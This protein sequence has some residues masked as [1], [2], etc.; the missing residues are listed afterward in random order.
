MSFKTKITLIL[1]VSILVSA[2]FPIVSLVLLYKFEADMRGHIQ[3]NVNNFTAINGLQT[4]IVRYDSHINRY[5]GTLN[6]NWIK[7]ANSVRASINRYFDA[8]QSSNTENSELLVVLGELRQEQDAYFRKVDQ[9]V[10]SPNQSQTKIS[11]LTRAYNNR[12]VAIFNKVNLLVEKNGEE[13]RE[14]SD[15]LKAQQAELEMMAIIMGSVFIPVLIISTA[16]IYRSTVTPINGI[17]EK[18]KGV[19]ADLPESIGKMV[20]DL[21]DFVKK[22]RPEDEISKLARTIRHLGKE[23]E[24][25]T[26][27]LNRLVVTDEKTR[28]FNF[29]HFK[30][31]L[32]TEIARAKRFGEPLSLIMLDIDNFKHYNDT[33]G[34]LLG[35]EVLIKV[36]RLMKQECRET[37]VPARFGGEEFAALLP[38]THPEEA[39]YVAERIRHVIEETVFVNQE[40]QPRGNLTV[41]LGVAT[42]PDDASDAEALINCADEA[43]YEAKNRGRNRVV[44]YAKFRQGIS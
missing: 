17:T 23:V 37:D 6:S 21:D 39:A 22:R 2:I 26:A 12:L 41:S 42:F 3:K 25:K 33:N 15:K 7:E 43:L 13:L 40:K 27:E 10:R 29:R 34:H 32:L 8:L 19:H 44:I 9:I 4:G 38:R 36:A 18:V 35:D 28:L 16:L 1:L 20:N 30:G 24:E 5:F 14:S 31:Q 11:D